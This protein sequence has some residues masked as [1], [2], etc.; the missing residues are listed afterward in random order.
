[1]FDCHSPAYFFAD[2]HLPLICEKGREDWI[3]HVLDFLNTEARKSKTLF[4]VGDIFDFWFEWKHSIPARAFRV[5]A[6]LERLAENGTRVIYLAGNHD[7]HLGSFL[8]TEVG[9]EITR[10]SFDALI[11]GRKIH[12]I[13][14]DGVVE[15][16]R[17]YRLLRRLVRWGPTEKVYRLV[18]P[19]FGI[20]FASK[21]SALSRNHLSHHDKFGAEPYQRYADKMLAAGFNYVVMGHRHVSKYTPHVNGGGFISVGGW[22]R[23]RSYGVF[24]DGS[25]RLE[26]FRQST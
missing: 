13:H 23:D 9:M 10:G 24:A 19:D 1:M 18:H 20:W 17:G 26:H 3:P 21:V 7:G 25:M 14:G 12:I 8:E 22:I 15:Q 5:L 6:A 16:D 11:D 4:L 2:S